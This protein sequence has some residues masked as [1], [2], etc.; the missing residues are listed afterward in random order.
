[1]SHHRHRIVP[2]TRWRPLEVV[3]LGLVLAVVIEAVTAFLRFGL[4]LQST[5]DTSFIAQYT[6][7]IRIH[8][9]YVGVLLLLAAWVV[10]KPP[11]ARRVAVVAGIALV[12]SDLLH[13]F[14]VLWPVTGD[15]HFDLVYP[16][17]PTPTIPEWVPSDVRIWATAEWVAEWVIRL[18]MLAVVPVRRPVS[19]ATA[20]LLTIFL[21]PWPGLGL[22]LLIGTVT[23][24]LE[25][26]KKLARF[27]AAVKPLV[28]RANAALPGRTVEVPPAW[29]AT[30]KLAHRLTKYPVVPGNRV[31]F[32]PD[33]A[34]T[35]AR[36][37]A[38]IDAAKHHAHLIF[39]IT[40]AD[41][42][43]EPVMAALVRAAARGVECRL[44]YDAHGSKDFAGALE[45]RLSGS[46]VQVQAALPVRWLGL[47][48]T[49]A[50]LRNHRKIAV[51]DG[52]VGWV[53]SMNLVDPAFKR[54]IVYE[55][56]SARVLGPVVT[57]L[58][59]TFAGDWWLEADHL[60][61]EP[62]YFPALEE[63]GTV[64]AQLLPSGPDFPTENFQ[65]VLVDMVHQSRE[66]VTLVT[67]YLIPDESL[68][69]AIETAS[70]RGVRVR[71]IVSETSDQ[72]LVRV[73]QESYYAQ[74]L[75]IGVELYR[76]RGPFLHAKHASADDAFAIV[77][78]GNADIRSFRL[79]AEAGL[80]LY[81]PAAVAEVAARQD[82]YIARAGRLTRE[83]WAG[84][85]RLR[86]LVE[87]LARIWSPLM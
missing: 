81:D 67:P 51:L 56:F 16:T 21:F 26:R 29:A 64:E 82:A 73:C 10:R 87:N 59:L 61:D 57:Q 37:A 14:A 66:T 54:G 40:S 78:S 84:R 33:A 63:V 7:G 76:Y 43:T 1:M 23:M 53:G 11:W 18:V 79:N 36:L 12:V 15:P 32:F 27:T 86:L 52:R 17:G 55:D 19:S 6:F 60:L 35:V 50:D 9:G 28:D 80:L 77:G 25:R 69:Q 38:D 20:W 65:R 2:P 42:A 44:V 85:G 45:R 62:P 70:L 47:R 4:H 58:Q 34:E 48:G 3:V 74:M 5:R 39:Y 30:A 75:A 41:A 68:L 22:F 46:G 83:A 72:F 49:R 8:H 71:V 31:E 24:P 13:H